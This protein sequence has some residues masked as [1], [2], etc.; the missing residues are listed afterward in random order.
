MHPTTVCWALPRYQAVRSPWVCSSDLMELTFEYYLYEVQENKQIN[1]IISEWQRR[2]VS[3]QDRE[4]G[5]VEWRAN[6]CWV[7]RKGLS[8]K[9]TGQERTSHLTLWD[10]NSPYRGSSRYKG[11]EVCGSLKSLKNNKKTVLAG[12]K[13]GKESS[14][15]WLDEARSCKVLSSIIKCS[16][17]ELWA[18][19]AEKWHSLLYRFKT[20]RNPTQGS[21]NKRRNFLKT[22]G[23]CQRNYR[24]K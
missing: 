9:V 21:F 3:K 5:P 14:L 6:I 20:F 12:T 4:K 15:Y 18:L 2:E 19:E 7:I 8:E 11:P 1:K 10:K 24:K 22:V 23:V 13:W 16:T 17:I